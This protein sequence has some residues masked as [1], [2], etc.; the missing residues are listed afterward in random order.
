MA[1]LKNK[2]KNND[3]LYSDIKV[4]LFTNVIKNK[5]DKALEKMPSYNEIQI[6][7]GLSLEKLTL[8]QHMKQLNTLSWFEKY[9]I[10]K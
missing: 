2:T 7:R 9:N 5:N 6:L 1:G 4:I 10:K 3:L 8:D